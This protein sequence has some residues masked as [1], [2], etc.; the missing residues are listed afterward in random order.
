METINSRQSHKLKIS[1]RIVVRIS[2][3]TTAQTQKFLA[4]TISSIDVAT[5]R[6]SL[7]GLPRALEAYAYSLLLTDLL[8]TLA[9]LGVVPKR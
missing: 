4:S 5:N 1:G 2:L 8:Q 9:D 7:R 3:V 6:T